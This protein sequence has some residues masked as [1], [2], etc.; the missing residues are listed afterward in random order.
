MI[1]RSVGLTDYTLPFEIVADFDHGAQVDSELLRNISIIDDIATLEELKNFGPRF[2]LG[3]CSKDYD[4]FIKST[5]DH[6]SGDAVFQSQDL[7]L[8]LKDLPHR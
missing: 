2:L 6:K 3:N 1:G 4:S 5:G 8:K 7:F